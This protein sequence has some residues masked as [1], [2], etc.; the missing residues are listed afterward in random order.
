VDPGLISPLPW[1]IEKQTIALPHGKFYEHWGI[2][3]ANGDIVAS[4]PNKADATQIVAAMAN[5]PSPSAP[6]CP[7]GSSGPAPSQSA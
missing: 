6:D 3:D 2:I 4:C 1:Q 5:T 7:G